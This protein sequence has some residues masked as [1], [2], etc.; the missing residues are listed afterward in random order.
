MINN[1]IMKLFFNKMESISDKALKE[2][3]LQHNITDRDIQGSGKNGR[4]LKSD[5]LK[6]YNQLSKDYLYDVKFYE[7]HKKSPEMNDD[8]WLNVLLQSDQETLKT[9]CMLNTTTA[10]ICNQSTFWK[11]KFEQDQLPY[12]IGVSEQARKLVENIIKSYGK[13][14]LH[15]DVAFFDEP[16]SIN[17]WISVYGQVLKAK[18][19]ANKLVN[20]IMKDKTFQKFFIGGEY[21][22]LFWMPEKM[23]QS[24]I[25][26]PDDAFEGYKVAFNIKKMEITLYYIATDEDEEESKEKLTINIKLTKDQVIDYLTKIFY[27]HPEAEL[28]YEGDRIYDF[29]DLQNHK[30]MKFWFPSW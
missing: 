12:L 19:I 25:K 30:K 11:L 13:N 10:K 9:S 21:Q 7:S 23:I 6:I 4:V 28:N 26:H 22:W 29:K 18:T 5:R 3:L 2:L 20:H 16:I 17:Q 14:V 1:H 27:Y 8:T 24:L 15:E